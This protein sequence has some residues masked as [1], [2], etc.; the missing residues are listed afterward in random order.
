MNDHLALQNVVLQVA[1]R[2]VNIHS[3]D[4]DRALD[5]A[6]TDLGRQ[7]EADAAFLLERRG[8]LITT[9]HAWL[10]DA[11]RAPPG[12]LTSS[13]DADLPS[14]QMLRDGHDRRHPLDP[15]PG[16]RLGPGARR[17]AGN[18][19]AHS[20]V[21]VPLVADDAVLGC[22]GLSRHR[23]EARWSPGDDRPAPPGR[24]GA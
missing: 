2:F 18:R 22:I 19:G 1:E 3:G 12:D 17:H 4:V 9:T 14:M 7:C 23:S 24:R 5:R 15:R 20:V 8:D 16:R 6:L 13:T 10:L 21:M 11:G